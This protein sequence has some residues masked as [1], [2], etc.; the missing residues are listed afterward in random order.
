MLYDFDLCP[1]LSP[2]YVVGQA[3]EQGLVGRRKERKIETGKWIESSP[4]LP[5]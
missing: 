4:L 3:G 5:S 2:L 1:V